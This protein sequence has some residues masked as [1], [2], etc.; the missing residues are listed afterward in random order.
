MAKIEETTVQ[1][2]EGQHLGPCPVCGREMVAGPSV[3][4][5][6][7]HPRSL[8]GRVAEPLHL[9]C[10]RK[11]HS[12]FTDK[13]LATTYATPEALQQRPQ[14]QTFIRWVRRRPPEFIDRH[15][16]PRV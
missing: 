10:H 5:H 12:L 8:G 14:M 16:K 3:D 1:A 13:E 11:L 9:I 7:W 6:H 15:K 2:G 4:R